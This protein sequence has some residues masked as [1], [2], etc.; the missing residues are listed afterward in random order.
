[1]KRYPITIS[2]FVIALIGFGL[3]RFTV[4]LAATEALEQFL[5]ASIVPL[6]LG[7]SLAAFG[8][9]LAVGAY[10]ATM[11]HTTARWCILGTVTMAALAL[12]TALGTEPGLLA[13][14]DSLREQAYLS[15]FLIGGAV[16]GT[17]T[18]LYAARTYKQQ[19]A[20]SQ[21]ANRLVLL[22]RLLRDQVINSAMAIKGH[23]GVLEEKRNP[24]SVGVVDRQ[25]DNI[26]DIV[27]NVKYL[28]ETADRDDISLESVDL[29]SCVETELDRVKAAYPEA[30][31][32]F[33]LPDE[34]VGVRA[35]S[36][37]SEV[38]RHLFENAIEYSDAETPQLV[39]TVEAGHSVTTVRV[40]DNGPGLPTS[41][42]R[43]LEEGEIAEFDDPTTGFG[44]NIVRLL[45]EGFD[46]EVDT[47]VDD[48]G[49]GIEV[50][51]PRTAN[52]DSPDEGF[53]F[54]RVSPAH[55]TLA[56]PVGLIAG[57]TMGAAMALTGFDIEAISSLYGIENVVVALIT[58]EFH[59]IV[60]ALFFAALLV[61]IPRQ[62]N[63]SLRHRIGIGVVFGL[64]LWVFAAGIVMPLWL[65]AV[66]I[67]TPL[68]NITLPSLVGHV[69][70]GTTTAVLFHAGDRWIRG[71]RQSNE[72]V[73]IPL[74][75]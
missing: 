66:G 34:A 10:D 16:G 30:E 74:F 55:T 23:A 67:D 61:V 49:T 36:Q 51:L 1:M 52:A 20:L 21:Q 28:S 32:G 73:S 2:G 42:Q 25:A 59:S 39:V 37:L 29:V 35:N 17:L 31:Y 57:I 70:W 26:V 60:F 7:L 45:V 54:S 68:P 3:T 58:H 40:R 19:T 50:R 62:Y 33:E 47:S 38:F 65:Q 75:G 41:Q 71:R 5:F 12:I 8:V 9:V 48:N 69:V 6:V 64:T 15:T 53:E 63:T 11:V 22:N 56:V 24:D 14:P 27:E 72:D 4:T 44:L 46:G 13:D 43:L 18:G